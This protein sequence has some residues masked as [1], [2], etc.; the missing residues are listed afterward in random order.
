MKLCRVLLLSLIMLLAMGCSKYE[1]VTGP[2]VQ[3]I[4][5]I[6]KAKT[7]S[8]LPKLART[9]QTYRINSW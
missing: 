8:D 7:G 9:A 4:D 1:Q 6:V 3:T 2:E 5:Y